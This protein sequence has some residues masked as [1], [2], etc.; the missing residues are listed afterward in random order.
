[1]TEAFCQRSFV[2][3]TVLLLTNLLIPGLAMVNHA[4]YRANS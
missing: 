2:T 3:A 4:S 1:V